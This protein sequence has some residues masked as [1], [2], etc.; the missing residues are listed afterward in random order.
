MDAGVGWVV[1]AI[2]GVPAFLAGT[3]AIWKIVRGAVHTQDQITKV[4]LVAERIEA[5]FANNGGSSLRDAIDRVEVKVDTLRE[6][7]DAAHAAIWQ[8][9]NR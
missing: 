5:E 1:A 4:L 8:A 2:V 7:K 6:E 9:I 3:K